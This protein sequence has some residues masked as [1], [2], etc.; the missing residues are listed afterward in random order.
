MATAKARAKINLGLDIIGRCDNGYHQ[1]RMVMQSIALSDTVTLKKSVENGDIVTYTQLLN[2]KQSPVPDDHSNLAYRAAKLL[3][4]EFGIQNAIEINI[5]KSIPVAAGLAGGSSDAAAVLKLMNEEF[6]LGLTIEKLQEF[7]LRLG[8]DIPYCL[9]GGT[10]L[11]EGIGEKLRPLSPMRPCQVLLVKPNEGISTAQAYGLYD[12]ASEIEHPNID[13]IIKALEHGDL[14]SLGQSMGNVLE[15]V[16]IP[17]LPVIKDIKD[18]LKKSGAYGVMMSGSGP[19]VFAIYEKAS[20]MEDIALDA[21]ANFPE[22]SIIK[23][24]IFNPD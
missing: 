2:G 9:I 17:L 10:K 14:S 13:S 19:T 18:Y 4:V 20:D 7:G 1:L 11:A 22:A 23:T 24:E 5:E 21:L 8:A 3:K 6:S 16:S 15:Y 12:R